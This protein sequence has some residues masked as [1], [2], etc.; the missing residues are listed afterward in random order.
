MCYSYFISIDESECDEKFCV[1]SVLKATDC[2]AAL[3]CSIKSPLW[4]ISEV[5]GM[6]C[7]I[8]SM[9]KFLVRVSEFFNCA[10]FFLSKTNGW[11]AAVCCSFKSPQ[12]TFYVKKHEC[13]VSYIYIVLMKLFDFLIVIRLFFFMK[14]FFSKTTGWIAGIQ[15]LI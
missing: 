2:F 8:L 4:G 1:A 10:F 12:R 15:Y 11:V 13:P 3:Q 14:L 6:P 9:P 7:F 5:S